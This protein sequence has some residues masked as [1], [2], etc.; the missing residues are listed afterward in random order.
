MCH[1]LLYLYLSYRF[2]FQMSSAPLSSS[3]AMRNL[4]GSR[5]FVLSQSGFMTSASSKRDVFVPFNSTVVRYVLV[6]RLRPLLG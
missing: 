4:F 3:L 6:L 1:I 2:L 5:N